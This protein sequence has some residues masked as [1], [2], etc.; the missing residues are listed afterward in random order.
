MERGGQIRWLRS[1]FYNVCIM[2]LISQFHNIKFSLS[3]SLSLKKSVALLPLCQKPVYQIFRGYFSDQL[4]PFLSS[5]TVLAIHLENE[6]FKESNLSDLSKDM[7]HLAS[8]EA[9]D[10]DKWTDRKTGRQKNRQTV[11]QQDTTTH[12][13]NNTMTLNTCPE[14]RIHNLDNQQTKY[15]V[16]MRPNGICTQYI[17]Y[18]NKILNKYF[19]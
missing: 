7:S 12:N 9:Q 18:I 15:T 19:T 16:R 17:T 3:L 4:F 13:N 2:P 5:C 1:L 11:K 6:C 10:N 14:H 8:D